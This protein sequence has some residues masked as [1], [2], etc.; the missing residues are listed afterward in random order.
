MVL[1]FGVALGIA[2]LPRLAAQNDWPAY[3]HDPG[4]MRYSPLHQIT[5]ANVAT[6]HR[7]WTYHTANPAGNS[8]RRPS[9]SAAAYTSRLRPAGSSR[10]NPRPA[11]SCGASIRRSSARENI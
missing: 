2:L 10:W 1:R 5:A 6:L 4:G 3:G 11:N 9:S 7:A 8:K